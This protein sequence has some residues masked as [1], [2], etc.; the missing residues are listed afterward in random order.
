MNITQVSIRGLTSSVLL[1]ISVCIIVMIIMAVDKLRDE[2]LQAQE[3]TLTRVIGIAAIE[4]LADT[5][6]LL[7]SLGS[8]AEKE[9]RKPLKSYLKAL[10]KNTPNK[11][12]KQALLRELLDVN[13]H[14]RYTTMGIVSLVKVRL[15]DKKLNFVAASTEGY[16]Q[17]GQKL[18]DFLHT[19]AAAREGP[20]RLKPLSGLWS[21]PEGAVYSTFCRW[22]GLGYVATLKLLPTRF[23]TWAAS[24]K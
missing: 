4:S 5:Q 17:L 10:S 23:I 3:S 8:D 16:S 7:I 11:A 22:A 12:E 18:P 13:F 15:Y 14:V 21:S 2:S 6:E 19:L 9:L 1:S 24:Q 20:Q